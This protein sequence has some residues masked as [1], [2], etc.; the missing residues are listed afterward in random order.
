L[1][2]FKGAYDSHFL[3]NQVSAYHAEIEEGAEKRHALFV[4]AI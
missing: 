4:H 1:L 3:I 2:F